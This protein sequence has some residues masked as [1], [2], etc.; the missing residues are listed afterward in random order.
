MYYPNVD[1]T[2]H[3]PGLYP[4]AMNG[5]YGDTALVNGVPWPAMQV[6]G[7][8]YRL[9]LLNASNARHYDLALDPPPPSGPAFVQ[10]GSD[11]GL[12]SAP[13]ALANVVM[14]PAERFDVVVDFSQ[15]P[16]GSR[17]VL[18]NNERTAPRITELMCF[19][20]VRREPETATVPARLA[21]DPDLPDPADAVR[22]RRFDF[23]RRADGRWG[24]NGALFDESRISAS[25]RLGSTEIWEFSSDVAH[26]VHLHLVHFRVLS[27]SRPESPEPW[28]GGWKDTVR[29]RAGETVRIVARFDGWRGKY[30]FHC[31]NLEHEDMMMMANFEVR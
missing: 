19:D 11:G 25:P 31:H 28:D 24:I 9:R 5:H 16:L 23:R 22:V 14:S 3:D 13:V 15:Y 1:P 7:T 26:P 29:L 12:L 2:L 18:R 21:P 20:V 10:I 4:W 17:V 30:V 8:K 27:R 6:S